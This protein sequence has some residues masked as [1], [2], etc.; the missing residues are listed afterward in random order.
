MEKKR[1]LCLDLDGTVR[2]SKS[3]KTFIEGP[4]DIEIIP[5][6]KELIWKYKNDG[7]RLIFISNQAGVAYGFKDVIQVRAENRQTIDLLRKEGSTPVSI[8]IFC[9]YDEKGKTEE[10]DWRSLRRKPMYGMLVEAECKLVEEYDIFPDWNNSLFVGD[11]PEDEECAKAAGIPFM[12]AHDFVKQ[13]TES[14]EGSTA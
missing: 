14:N 1:I 2:R 10:Y 8:G 7:W 11:R 6:M 5:G 13:K 3:G 4:D 12:W 9:P